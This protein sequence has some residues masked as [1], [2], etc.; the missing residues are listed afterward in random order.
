[1]YDR[2]HGDY[3]YLP[4]AISV[5]DLRENFLQRL[6]KKGRKDVAMPCVEWLRLQFHPQNP[7]ATKAFQH[8]GRFPIKSMVQ[9]RIIRKQHI[10]SKF[11]ALQWQYAKEFMF[12]WR[13]YCAV[14][15]ID[16]KAIVPIGEPGLPIGTAQRGQKRNTA[17]AEGS[18]LV[19]TDHDYHLAGIVP[20]TMLLG[21][22]PEQKTGSFFRGKL[23]VTLKDR[24]FT[25]LNV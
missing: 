22:I 16:D 12:D 18:V 25:I 21:E 1:M 9:R 7:W 6:E 3:L 11:C 19:A 23:H 14:I 8:T 20:S 17:P 24:F 2:R 5:R 15:Y 4:F 13:D 10:D